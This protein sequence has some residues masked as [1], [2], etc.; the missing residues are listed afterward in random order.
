LRDETVG[1]GDRSRRPL[2]RGHGGR[3]TSSSVAGIN[4]MA[5]TNA[6]AASRV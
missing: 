6:S 3:G 2:E 1:P 5:D 4:S